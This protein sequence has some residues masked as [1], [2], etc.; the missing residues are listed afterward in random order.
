MNNAIASV[1]ANPKIA[2]LNISSLKEGFLD[3]PRTKALKIAP[4]PTPA[5]ANPIVAN[6][7]PKNLAACGNISHFKDLR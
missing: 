5:P 1:R 2:N 3:T 7:A 4:I 6:P